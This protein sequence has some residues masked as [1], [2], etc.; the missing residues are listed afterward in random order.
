MEVIEF[1]TSSW[2]AKKKQLNTQCLCVFLWQNACDVHVYDQIEKSISSLILRIN[3]ER[4][5]KKTNRIVIVHI[6]IYIHMKYD[7][8]PS[9]RQT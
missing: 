6:Y 7:N 9:E 8:L 3:E 4:T 2:K 5:G 1:V